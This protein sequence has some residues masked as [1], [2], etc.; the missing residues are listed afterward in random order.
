MDRFMTRVSRKISC[1]TGHGD[2]KA[3]S[4]TFDSVL[5][6]GESITVILSAAK[7]LRMFQTRSFAALRMTANSDSY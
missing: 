6:I 5:R 4:V 1:S 2:S 3:G 7:D